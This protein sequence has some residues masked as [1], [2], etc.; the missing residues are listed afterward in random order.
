LVFDIL[1]PL[2]FWLDPKEPLP[3]AQQAGKDQGCKSA[4]K[5]VTHPPKIGNKS[6]FNF[7]PGM[8]S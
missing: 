4:F 5:L 8:W 1:F 6:Q 7:C 3:A 2:F